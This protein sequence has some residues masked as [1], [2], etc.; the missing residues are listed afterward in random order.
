MM[1]YRPP[2]PSAFGMDT[3]NVYACA[4]AVLFALA[5]LWIGAA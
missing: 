3:V 4:V 2:A 5:C 1:F